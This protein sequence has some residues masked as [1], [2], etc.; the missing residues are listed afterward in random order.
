MLRTMDSP[1]PAAVVA[2]VLLALASGCSPVAASVEAPTQPVGGSAAPSAAT[3]RQEETRDA[4]LA[5]PP[6]S[7]PFAVGQVWSGTY[8]CPQ[9]STEARLRLEG[10]EG[11]RL[12]GTLEFHHRA[13]GNKGSFSVVGGFDPTT[14]RL[15]FAPVQWIERPRRYATIGF[16]GEVEE[17]RYTGLVTNRECGPFDFRRER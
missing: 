13:S 5:R 4:P 12:L 6:L 9:G 11:T 7:E 2:V 8:T 3:Q 15:A 10:G 17:D 14:S 1:G 16:D